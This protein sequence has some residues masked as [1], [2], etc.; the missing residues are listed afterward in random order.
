[1]NDERR[2]PK[3]PIL[4]VGALILDG[5]R[6]V[7]VRRA[8]PPNEGW[9]SLPGGAVETGET[10]E[11]ALRREVLEETGLRVKELE[12]A[13]VF[14]R[15]TPDDDGRAEYHYVLIDYVCRVEASEPRAGSDSLEARWFH[16][17]ELGELCITEGTLEVVERIF[18][19]H[20][21]KQS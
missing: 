7:M 16:R 17:H 9:W 2:Y 12:L 5:D 1:M 10:I 21:A 13:E 11:A 14:E 18:E 8:K 4:G 6:I 3:R 20:A 19:R 15:I